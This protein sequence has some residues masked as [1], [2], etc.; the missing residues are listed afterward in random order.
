MVFPTHAEHPPTR[1]IA[2]ARVPTAEQ[3]LEETAWYTGVTVA[4]PV[5]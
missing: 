1:R 5:I 4:V 3:L 2:G